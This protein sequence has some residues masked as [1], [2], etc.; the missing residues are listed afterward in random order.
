MLGGYAGRFLWVDLSGYDGAFFSGISE[1]PVY[2][3]LDG[4]RAELRDA[5]SLWGSD[6]YVTRPSAPVTVTRQ[7]GTGL[8]VCWPSPMQVFCR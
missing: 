4:G 5:G 1:R 7:P 3:Y 2:L 6:C 8:P